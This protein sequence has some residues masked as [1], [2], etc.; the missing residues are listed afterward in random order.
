ML[1][2]FLDKLS[3]RTTQSLRT[4]NWASITAAILF[5]L[6]VTFNTPLLFAMTLTYTVDIPNITDSYGDP[7]KIAEYAAEIGD[8]LTFS[9]TMD[10]GLT[11]ADFASAPVTAVGFATGFGK[12]SFLSASHNDLSQDYFYKQIFGDNILIEVYQN[13]EVGDGDIRLTFDLLSNGDA[14][15][16][17]AYR[18]GAMW[19]L[20]SCVT[21]SGTTTVP[22]PATMVLLGLGLVGLAGVRRKFKK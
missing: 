20:E 16:E 14:F 10:G 8:T 9:V 22:E 4:F 11:P 18:Q 3:R 5:F 7:A 12:F 1:R 13:H 21:K 6:F 19:G 2:E 17:I 15:G